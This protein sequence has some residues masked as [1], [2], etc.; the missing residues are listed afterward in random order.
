[1]MHCEDHYPLIGK[2]YRSVCK[3]RIGNQIFV[4]NLFV[5]L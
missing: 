5:A 4:L 1:M 3:V 2:F